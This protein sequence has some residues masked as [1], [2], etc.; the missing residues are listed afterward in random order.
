MDI[1][2]DKIR[3]HYESVWESGMFWELYPKLSGWWSEDKDEFIKLLIEKSQKMDEQIDISPK[4]HEINERIDEN[5]T[6]RK[7]VVGDPIRKEETAVEYI[8]QNY[9]EMANEFKK[10]QKKQYETFCKKQYNYGSSNIMLGGDNDN[11]DDTN[12]A[13]S[14]V[15]IRMSD[16]VNRLI[17]L[18]IKS[19]KDTVGESTIDSF[20]DIS[21]YAIIAQIVNNRKWGK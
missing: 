12:F 4:S 1:D 5:Y 21:V 9:P 14:G 16:K 17:N 2:I 7:K 6:P 18:I 11:D 13:L 8:E 19:K 3:E 15:V 10:I 20:L